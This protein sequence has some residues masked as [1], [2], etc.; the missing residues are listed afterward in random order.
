MRLMGSVPVGR[1]VYTRQA[2]PAVEMVN[3][4]LRA[5]RCPVRLGRPRRVVCHPRVAASRRDG[6]V[7]RPA[8]AAARGVSLFQQCV[9]I[10]IFG[11]LHRRA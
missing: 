7:A 3:F 2:L 6:R 9:V 4:A 10:A 1:I 8:F 5:T 11:K